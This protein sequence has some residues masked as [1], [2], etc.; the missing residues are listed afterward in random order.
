[1]YY[2]AAAISYSSCFEMKEDVDDDDDDEGNK[3]TH[4]HIRNKLFESLE[5][6][7]LCPNDQCLC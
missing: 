3:E 1:M 5:F 7:Y 2:Y 4:S 6:T